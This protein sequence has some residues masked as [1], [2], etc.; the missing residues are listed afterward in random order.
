MEKSKFGSGWR[1]GN[2]VVEEGGGRERKGNNCFELRVGVMTVD[3]T[4]G[5]VSTCGGRGWLLGAS[6]RIEMVDIH[7]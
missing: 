6:R 5:S 3:L 4:D 2:D 7:R 1:Q